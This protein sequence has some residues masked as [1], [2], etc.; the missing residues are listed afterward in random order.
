MQLFKPD[1]ATYFTG[2]GKIGMWMQFDYDRAD[3]ME[4][5]VKLIHNWLNEADSSRNTTRKNAYLSG[6]NYLYQW[7]TKK[8]Y[9]SN[10]TIN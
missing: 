6:A 9:Q 2:L 7:I 10:I 4:E 1:L 3:D 5:V 8:S